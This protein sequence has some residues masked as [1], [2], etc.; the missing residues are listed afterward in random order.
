MTP[1][2]YLL[3]IFLCCSA[4]VPAA[5]RYV[6][7]DNAGGGEKLSI[8]GDGMQ[9]NHSG[10][11]EEHVD[12]IGIRD[13]NLDGVDDA[14]VS[15]W[16]GGTCCTP[17]FS[18]VSVVNGGLIV[19]GVDVD[20]YEVTIEEIGGRY[21]LRHTG[22]DLSQ[23]FSFDGA[24]VTRHSEIPNL[25]ALVEVHGPG[26]VYIDEAPPEKLVFDIDDDGHDDTIACPVWTRWGS[27]LCDM[28]LPDGGT[29]SA[30]S[31]CARVGVLA[32]KNNGYHE[33]VCD[34]DTVITFDGRQWVEKSDP[35]G[36]V[37]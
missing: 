16:N 35:K 8:E 6:V 36:R 30:H 28:P 37:F 9:E 18:V 32:T 20:A 7:I 15:T 11:D 1:A 24:E 23:L 22:P 5:V 12:I 4:C 29:Q 21:F 2:R 33:F 19:A 17:E 10:P 13:F 31:G 14:L 3:L 25:A 34:F 27:L 26:G